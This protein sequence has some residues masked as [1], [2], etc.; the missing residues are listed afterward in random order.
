MNDVK[1]SSLSAIGLAREGAAVYSV[2]V[3]EDVDP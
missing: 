2:F 3:P 1:L